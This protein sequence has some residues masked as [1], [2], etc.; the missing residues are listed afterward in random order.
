MKNIW[1]E[2]TH[3][4]SKKGQNKTGVGYYTHNIIR[5][6]VG[7][8]PKDQY[9]VFGARF[10]EKLDYSKDYP[11]AK[12]RIIRTLPGKVWNQLIKK[13]LM[14]PLEAMYRSK[15]DVVVFFNFVKLPTLSITKTVVVIHDLAFE[16]F[17]EYIDKKNLQ[18]LKKFVPQSIKRADRIVAVSEYT[19]RDI[20]A[21]YGVKPDRISVVPNAVDANY[22]KKTK[23]STAVRERYGL[24]QNYILFVGTIEPRKNLATLIQA[25]KMLPDEMRH[26]YPLLIA[27]MKGWVEQEN[28]LVDE[29]CRDGGAILTGYVDHTDLPA[30]YSG[31]TVLLMPSIFE[32]FGIPLLEPM[33]CGVPVVGANNSSIP[34]VINGAGELFKTGDHK[35]LNKKLVRVLSDTKYRKSLEMKGRD[36]VKQ[37]SWEKS[38][39]TLQDLI[40]SL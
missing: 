29:Y 16:H 31:A 4:M 20:I 17:P 14:P 19:K 5:N 35:D 21:Q 33:A 32:G 12:V 1:L 3:L 11:G 38:A 6:L 22:F 34:E 37:Y 10:G 36:R 28:A 39:R 7:L 24:P 27:G 9:V 18:Y 30:I 26:K 15:P 25:H 2:A 23:V 13:N 8:N 40:D